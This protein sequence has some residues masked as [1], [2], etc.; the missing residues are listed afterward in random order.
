[1]PAPMLGSAGLLL[2]TWPGWQCRVRMNLRGFL[3]IR[4]IHPY[5]IASTNL[6]KRASVAR[7]L[8]AGAGWSCGWGA[9]LRLSG[10]L[11]FQQEFMC[12]VRWLISGAAAR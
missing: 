11:P 7:A 4:R 1:M 9:V 10:E 2:P 8:P 12:T 6:W 3:C 5:L